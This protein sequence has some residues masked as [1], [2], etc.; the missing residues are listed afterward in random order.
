MFVDTCELYFGH[1]YYNN[2]KYNPIDVPWIG[3]IHYP[4]KTHYNI[5]HDCYRD[6]Q[7]LLT[8]MDNMVLNIDNFRK[9]LNHCKCLFV[10]TEYSKNYLLKK[11]YLK[12]IPIHNISHPVSVSD[13]KNHFSIGQINNVVEHGHLVLI[14][15]QDR[16]ISDLFLIKT[17]RVK[18]WIGSHP[19]YNY[20]QNSFMKAGINNIPDNQTFNSKIHK[21]RRI[22][23]NND[24]DKHLLNNIC[25]VPL[26]GSQTNNTVIEILAMKIPAFVSRNSGTEEYLGINYPMFY[27]NVK[28]INVIIDNKKELSFLMSKTVRY[29]NTYEKLLKLPIV[30]EYAINIIESLL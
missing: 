28:D 16:R 12:D 1:R 8:T 23:D 18:H 13:F 20:V 25:L 6:K 19:E 2:T 29:L 9:S 11:P 26:F 5:N 14:G 7:N 21:Y 27:N 17:N 30:E 3:I 10:T 4:P 22:N 24:Y 15:T